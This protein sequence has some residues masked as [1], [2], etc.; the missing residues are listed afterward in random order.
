MTFGILFS[1]LATN[2][3]VA[4]RLAKVN[5]V[6][7]LDAQQLTKVEALMVVTDARRVELTSKIKDKDQLE[8]SLKIEQKAYLDK[9]MMILND[10]QKKLYFAARNKK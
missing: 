9:L 2:P 4:T 10:A 1:V 8:K 6:V 7:H 3:A 5:S